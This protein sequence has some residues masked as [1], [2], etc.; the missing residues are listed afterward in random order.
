MVIRCWRSF[1]WQV[2]MLQLEGA[3]RWRLHRCPTGPL[4][5]SYC[6]DYDEKDLGG[7][8]PNILFFLIFELGEWLFFL[9]IA[10]GKAVM[11][12]TRFYHWISLVYWCWRCLLEHQGL[13]KI[14]HTTAFRR[15]ESCWCPATQ[16][17]CGP[18]GHHGTWTCQPWRHLLLPI[19]NK[20]KQSTHVISMNEH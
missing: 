8:L 6:W 20:P 15:L 14:H 17:T 12:P 3:K 7:W 4:P 1:G 19:G 11:M 5:R 16:G 10:H 13:A 18:H 9:G 2:F